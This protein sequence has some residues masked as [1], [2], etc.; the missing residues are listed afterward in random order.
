MFVSVIHRSR[1]SNVCVV[2]TM[3]ETKEE[4]EKTVDM[5]VK[6]EIS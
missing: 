2:K 6:N 5:M 4:E 1:R 3:N